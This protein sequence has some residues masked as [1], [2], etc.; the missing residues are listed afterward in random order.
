MNPRI[1]IT[2]FPETKLHLK[3]NSKYHKVSLSGLAASQEVVLYPNK[4]QLPLRKKEYIQ[5]SELLRL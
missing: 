4:V 5:E 3:K 1:E 2:A